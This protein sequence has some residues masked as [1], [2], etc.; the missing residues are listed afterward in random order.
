MCPT[1]TGSLTVTQVRRLT[2]I[3][4]PASALIVVAFIAARLTSLTTLTDWLDNLHWTI[5]YVTAAA[6]GWLGVRWSDD[7]SRNARRW[8]A[9]G[10]T[11]SALGQLLWDVQT[12]LH[13]TG[14]PAPSDLLF[15][16]F[17][18][19][20]V[21]GMLHAVRDHQPEAFNWALILDAITLV[22]MIVALVLALYLPR[23]TGDDFIELAFMVAYP[24]CMLTSTC[25]AL[26][27]WPTLRLRMHYSWLTFMVASI[28]N[29]LCWLQ[30]IYLSQSDSVTTNTWL[31]LLFSLVTPIL[32]VGVVLWRIESSKDPVVERRCEAILRMLPLLVVGGAAIS[33]GLA[34]SLPKLPRAAALAIYVSAGVV[35]VLAAI[36]QSLLLFERERL[37]AVEKRHSELERSFQTLFLNTRGG[38]AL[39]DHSG[40]FCE[41]NPSCT[42]LLGYSRDELLNM[43]LGDIRMLPIPSLPGALGLVDQ[44]GNGVIETECQRKD[45][46]PVHVELT[47]ALIP[48][49]GGQVFVIFRN[50]T[51]RKQAS[52]QL[53]LM[54]QRLAIA[55]RSAGI[56]I[57]EYQPSND[58]LVWDAQMC[59]L[60]G[61]PTDTFE[62]SYGE[63]EKRI[64]PDDLQ[65]LQQQYREAVAHGKEYHGEFRII[66]P[67]GSTRHLEVRADIPVEIAGSAQR[68]IGVNWDITERKQTEA[69]QSRLEAQLRQSQKLEAVGTLASGIAH[70]FNN[71]LGAIL[72]NIELA[73]QDVGNAHPAQTS[74]QEIRKAGQRA[75]ELIRRI[76][77]FG[78]P[79]ELNFRLSQLT[80]VIEDSVK[81]VRATM[82]TTVEIHCHL[83]G[84]IP[85][86]KVDSSQIVQVLL[87]LCT[88]AYQAMDSQKG[89]IDITLDVS[90][91]TSA[92]AL[93]STDLQPGRHVCLHV[94]DNGVGIDPAAADRIFEPFFTTKPVGE[95]S[96][97]GLSIV[98]GIVRNHGGAITVDSQPGKGSTFHV[99]LPAPADQLGEEAPIVTTAM[100]VKSGNGQHILYVDD[101]EP[102]VF[103]TKRM[104]ERFGYRVSGYTE[105]ETA[106]RAVL[107]GTAHFDLVITDQ[108]M[109]GMSGTDLAREILREHPHSRIMLVSGYLPPREIETA[110]KLGIHE[111]LLKPDTVDELATAVHRLLSA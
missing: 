54:A 107:D 17:G 83:A 105:A 6:L 84:D 19:C 77:A 35:F 14:Y 109:P 24:I 44:D 43:N 94:R 110:R 21:W 49:S 67:D 12:A 61:L 34:W 79:H 40:N 66:R 9:Y 26:V 23:Y 28:V 90:N 48:D 31:Y 46:Q 50:I 65:R 78:K 38:L 30:W 95:G 53:Q 18:P 82:P 51:E 91:F 1:A 55:T 89:R 71:I 97:L 37:L 20:C 99:Y 4:I 45:G 103:L 74:L 42:T 104:L 70:D 92:S 29:G 102:L 88:N 60:Y 81:L 36:R 63:W 93:P 52:E 62:G 10:L 96:G 75:R 111:V 69:A 11:A 87:N 86:V 58:T 64:H 7:T 56:G 106:L 68:M 8:F 27:M 47:S 3:L 22:V 16:C 76:V 108:S 57:W 5:G 85:L 32:G 33:V 15:V 100:E 59:A 80:A 2:L 73:L 41:L 25:L 98:H 39:L 72:G 101:E 13:W